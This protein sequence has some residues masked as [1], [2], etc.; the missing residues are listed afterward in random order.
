MRG[1]FGK[2][3]AS[4]A[5][6]TNPGGS[7]AR[8]L[9]SIDCMVTKTLSVAPQTAGEAPTSASNGPTRVGFVSLGCPKNLV[10][11][12]VMMGLLAAGR[13]Q[14]GFGRGRSRRNRGQHLLVHR[15]RPA[16]VGQHHPGNGEAQDHW[17]RPE[18]G[19]RRLPGGTFSQRNSAEH[20]GSGRRGRNG[21]AGSHTGGHRSG[22]RA[23]SSILRSR[24]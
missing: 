18:A 14:A 11:S 9:K 16:G 20:S 6:A 19:G 21:R 1:G 8:V 15:Q 17:A 3:S 7:R 12:E 2:T 24:F 22:S 5:S 4:V 23:G 10:D 13:G